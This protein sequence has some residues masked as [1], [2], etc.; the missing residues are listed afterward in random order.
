MKDWKSAAQ[1]L[2]PAIPAAE[3]ERIAA[4]LEALERTFRPL[5]QDLPPA[6]EPDSVFHPDE[7]AE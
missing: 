3:A 4:P 6:L 7:E 5:A 2:A 1:A